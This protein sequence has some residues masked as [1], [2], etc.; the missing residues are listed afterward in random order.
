[1]NDFNNYIGWL[2]GHS[3]ARGTRREVEDKA[4]KVFETPLYQEWAKPETLFKITRGSRQL[5]VCSYVWHKV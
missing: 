4:R 1:M 5:F 3:V 2:G